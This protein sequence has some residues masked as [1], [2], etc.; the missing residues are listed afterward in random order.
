MMRSISSLPASPSQP[1][2]AVVVR[3]W[4][5]TG[6]IPCSPSPPIVVGRRV[7]RSPSMDIPIFR[8]RVSGCHTANLQY[9][10]SPSHR[11]W[12]RTKEGSFLVHGPKQKSQT[13]PQPCPPNEVWTPAAS[14]FRKN[15][16]C[17]RPA[18]LL[19]NTSVSHIFSS[20]TLLSHFD[21]DGRYPAA[22]RGM[23]LLSLRFAVATLLILHRQSRA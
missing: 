22:W 4:S 10:F 16:R 11:Q 14:T 3:P 20:C 9:S 8:T 13:M 12:P 18:S 2:F 1:A 17:R 19:K 15:K 21:S 5:P 23:L 7:G 6:S